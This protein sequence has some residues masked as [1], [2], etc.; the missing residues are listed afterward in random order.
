MWILSF[1]AASALQVSISLGQNPT[2][3]QPYTLTCNVSVASEVTGTPTVQWVGPGS[4]AP[5]VTGGDFTVSSTSPYTLTINPL[6]LSHAGQ[7]TC[8]ARVRN[9]TNA[10][11][12]SLAFD[13][14]TV[15]TKFEDH[16]NLE[17]EH[18]YLDVS[19]MLAIHTTIIKT[20]VG[21]QPSDKYEIIV[22]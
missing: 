18:I 5:I 8:Q 9:V 16:A 1:F 20:K 19:Q 6:H 7:Y 15:L 13:G 10:A 12:V 21:N 11:S 2:L 3:G 17:L 4:S 14:M 22:H